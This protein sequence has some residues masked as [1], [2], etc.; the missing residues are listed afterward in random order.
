MNKNQTHQKAS[1]SIRS[2]TGYTRNVLVAVAVLVVASNATDNP[3]SFPTGRPTNFP[4]A[5]TVRPTTFPTFPTEEQ[6]EA[7]LDLKC[8]PEDT[9]GRESLGACMDANCIAACNPSNLVFSPRIDDLTTQEVIDFCSKCVE[10]GP[11]PIVIQTSVFLSETFY[12]ESN[13]CIEEVNDCASFGEPVASDIS[14]S[15]ND[16]PPSTIKALAGTGAAI[17]LLAAFFAFIFYKRRQVP[18]LES[19]VKSVAVAPPVAEVVEPGYRLN[20]T[21]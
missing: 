6:I 21:Y 19:S 2:M 8:D 13:K 15:T 14:P 16:L 10:P 5:P 4:T 1:E 9:D 11:N 3:T 12:L 17:V 20:P 18:G 7:V